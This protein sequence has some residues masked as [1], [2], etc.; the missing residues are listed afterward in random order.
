MC[1][2]CVLEAIGFTTGAASP[3]CFYNKTRDI[4]VMVHGDDFTAL[5]KDVDFYFYET[6]L[7]ENFELKI[8]G[9][10]GEG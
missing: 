7:A 5:G 1:Y 10:V 3:C 8:R 6:K 4:S 9:R 2:R